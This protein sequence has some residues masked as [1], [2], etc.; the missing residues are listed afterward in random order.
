MKVI[1]KNLQLKMKNCGLFFVIFNF[2]FLIFNCLYSQTNPEM[3]FNSGIDKYVKGD[4]DGAVALFEQTLSESPSHQKAKNF[5]VKVLIEATE[6]QIMV[7]NFQKAKVYAD[8]AKII[9]PDDEKVNELQ[10]VI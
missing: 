3:Y 6:K 9:A 5:L 8:R 7:S 2:T 10:K 4:Y 1:I